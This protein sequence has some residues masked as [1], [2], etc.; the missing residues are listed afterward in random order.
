MT[1]VIIRCGWIDHN[2]GCQQSGHSQRP[3]R[4]LLAAY[5]A[6]R[7]TFFEIYSHALQGRPHTTQLLDGIVDTWLEPATKLGH[8]QGKSLPAARADARLGLAVVRGLLLDLLATGDR[9]GVDAA[10]ER[11]ITRWEESEQ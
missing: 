11:F 9:A 6:G 4:P 8:Q 7:G 2:A 5:R 1:A 3:G 10:M